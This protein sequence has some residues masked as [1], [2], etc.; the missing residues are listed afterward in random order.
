MAK[1]CERDHDEDGNCDRHP[2]GCPTDR[3][4]F[5]VIAVCSDL[6]SIHTGAQDGSVLDYEMLIAWLRWRVEA[7]WEPSRPQFSETEDSI[8]AFA[9]RVLVDS[10]A[11]RART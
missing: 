7:G 6:H 3:Y 11:W 10:V 1:C 4:Q 2:A 5:S 8:R 9:R